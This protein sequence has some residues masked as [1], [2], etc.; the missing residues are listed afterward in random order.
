MNVDMRRFQYALDPVRRQGL[1]RLEALQALQASVSRELDAERARLDE[2]R[3]DHAAQCRAA[4]QALAERFDPAAYQPLVRWLA[5]LRARIVAREGEV[6]ALE[7][8]REE[9]GA[10]CREQQRKVDAV[11]KHREECVAEF[12]VDEDSRLA[13]EADRDWLTRLGWA[14]GT[15]PSEEGGP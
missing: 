10:Q 8:R 15:G 4:E 6:A 12:R 7:R 1:W 5:Q 2:L 9:V 14:S 11:E 3:S 13:T